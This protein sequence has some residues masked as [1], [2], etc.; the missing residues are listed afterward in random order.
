LALAGIL[1]RQCLSDEHR[2]RVCERAMTMY[3]GPDRSE[4]RC[5]GPAELA[6]LCAEIPPAPP[7][8]EAAPECP[9]CHGDGFEE[10]NGGYRRCRCGGSPMSDENRLKWSRAHA[11]GGSAYTGPAGVK[12]LA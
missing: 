9:H 3:F 12:R 6:D 8:G 5:P 11:V 10:A 4:D 7:R 2:R 1:D